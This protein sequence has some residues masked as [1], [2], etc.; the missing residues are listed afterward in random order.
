MHTHM[1]T[2]ARKRTRTHTRTRTR[3][4]RTPHAHPHPHPHMHTHAPPQVLAEA[5]PG[6]LHVEELC[7]EMQR[8]G[9]RDLRSSKTPEASVAG[10][11]S[12]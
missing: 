8:R 7:R 6:G 1:H 5:G 11:M 2:H 12:K 9:L 3:T 4:L 10:A